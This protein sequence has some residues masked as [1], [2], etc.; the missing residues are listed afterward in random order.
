MEKRVGISEC[1][2][3]LNDDVNM[4]AKAILQIKEELKRK[5]NEIYE[6]KKYILIILVYCL[7]S[8]FFCFG[9]LIR[10]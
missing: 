4:M 1:I 9:V 2:L 8:A 10:H 3:G 7:F 5:D 6:L